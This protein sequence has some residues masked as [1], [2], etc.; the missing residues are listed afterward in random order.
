MTEKYLCKS[1]G[2]YKTASGMVHDRRTASGLS[3][4]CKDPCKKLLNKNDNIR[5]K[6]EHT[7]NYK[8]DYHP[9]S[10]DNRDKHKME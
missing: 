6:R 4:I 3:N 8:D 7:G 2:Q 1:C 9:S 5:A 10:R